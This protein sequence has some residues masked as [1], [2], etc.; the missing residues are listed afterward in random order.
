MLVIYSILGKRRPFLKQAEYKFRKNYFNIPQITSHTEAPNEN[1][2]IGKIGAIPTA[3]KNIQTFLWT[4]SNFSENKSS[5]NKIAEASIIKESK[6]AIKTSG[7]SAIKSRR[8]PT[9]I[10]DVGA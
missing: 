1:K 8:L 6:N 3:A 4:I 10:M 5:N 9:K 2:A 7:V